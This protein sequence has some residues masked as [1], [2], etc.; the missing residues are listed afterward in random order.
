MA[1]P[2]KKDRTDQ[3]DENTQAAGASPPPAE[4]GGDG[5]VGVRL[6][7][8][9]VCNIGGKSYVFRAGER[10]QVPFNVKCVLSR[11]DLLRG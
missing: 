5:L 10:T 1:V 3:T 8:D 11:A 4:D 7:R 2:S 9:H 6:A